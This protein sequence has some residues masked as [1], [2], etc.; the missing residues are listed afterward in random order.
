MK[1]VFF[2]LKQNFMWKLKFFAIVFFITNMK[3]FVSYAFYY[4]SDKI[5]L[6]EVEL[7]IPQNTY[8]LNTNLDSALAIYLTTEITDKENFKL[9]LEKLYDP[10]RESCN[11]IYEEIKVLLDI[12]KNTIEA[13][14]ILKSNIGGYLNYKVPGF[15]FGLKL[16]GSNIESDIHFQLYI[17][18]IVKI[19]NLYFN[20]ENTRIKKA[21]ECWFT[22]EKKRNH[23]KNAIKNF[24]KKKKELE[25]IHSDK[26][27]AENIFMKTKEYKICLNIY[28]SLIRRY[29]KKI[30][31]T[32]FIFSGNY[33]TEI[34]HLPIIYAQKMSLYDQFLSLCI[35]NLELSETEIK[36][37]KNFSESQKIDTKNFLKPKMYVAY[38]LK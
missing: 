25:N 23:I 28:K 32:Q 10:F 33:T 3:A 38:L 31:A 4:K 17:V 37:F 11:Q 21:V 19:L 5:N 22:T 12:S 30:E 34:V 29:T 1:S 15:F 8:D 26:T 13:Y 24:C 9:A 7:S 16:K 18:Y 6:E 20:D 36:I 27:I 2:T 14:K 35:R